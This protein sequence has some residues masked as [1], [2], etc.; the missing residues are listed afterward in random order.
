MRD[1]KK[2]L[3]NF[4]L[5][6]PAQLI[7]RSYKCNNLYNALFTRTLLIREIG[8]A[9]TQ[10]ET[11]LKHLIGVSLRLNDFFFNKHKHFFPFGFLSGSML[12]VSFSTSSER[13]GNNLMCFPVLFRSGQALQNFK[14]SNFYILLRTIS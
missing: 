10:T 11:R 8:Y 9:C 12:L 7:S 13:R 1:G 6:L 14:Y 4:S 5:F 3:P 2:F